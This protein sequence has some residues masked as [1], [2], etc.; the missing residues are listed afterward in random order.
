MLPGGAGTARNPDSSDRICLQGA[1]CRAHLLLDRPA[2]LAVRPLS[3]TIGAEI[4]GV[5]LRGRS[6][7]P[8]SPPYGR[9]GSGYKVVVFADQHL[10]PAEQ[11]AFARRFGTLTPAHPV[12]PGPL[13]EHPRGPRPRQPAHEGQ[14]RVRRPRGPGRG[15]GAGTPTSPSCP[16]RP[17]GRSCPGGSCPRPAGTRCGPT[18][19]PPTSASTEPLR[20]LVDGLTAVHDGRRTFG[21]FLAAG[22]PV[23]WDGEEHHDLEPGRAPR[24]AHPPRDRPAVTVREP[25]VH[26]PH[27]RPA[28]GAT[29]PPCSTCSTPT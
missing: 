4:R 27:R 11:V 21:G 1:V 24:G 5:D 10:E 19:R 26:V 14:P 22:H 16:P 25:P 2:G 7:T 28:V 23:R 3:G 9:C 12:V 15:S 13:A 6:T 29:A 18:P 20:R 17:P 8:P